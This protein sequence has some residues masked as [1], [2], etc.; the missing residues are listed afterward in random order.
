MLLPFSF[1]T[2]NI[3]FEYFRLL[4]V[5]PFC[6][7]PHS[8]I[9]VARFLVNNNQPRKCQILQTTFSVY[10]APCAHKPHCIE[11]REHANKPFTG[12]HKLYGEMV[13]IA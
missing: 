5:V 9:V 4:F 13:R 8:G 6:S 11:V 12:T 3:T 1:G 2:A 7:F 10:P